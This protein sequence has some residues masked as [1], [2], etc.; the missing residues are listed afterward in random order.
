MKIFEARNELFPSR[1]LSE[2]LILPLASFGRVSPVYTYG[3]KVSSQIRIMKRRLILYT[4]F[5]NDTYHK[6]IY[7]FDHL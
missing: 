6:V 3:N 4:M 5:S 7:K 2:T 1:N